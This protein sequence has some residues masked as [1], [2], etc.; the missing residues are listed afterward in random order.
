MPSDRM[1][2]PSPILAL[3]ELDVKH[4]DAPKRSRKHRPKCRYQ[5]ARQTGLG[6]RARDL[7]A[8]ADAGASRK[9]MSYNRSI[10]DFTAGALETTHPLGTARDL[11]GRLNRPGRDPANE[12][13]PLHGHK[14][15]MPASRPPDRA[16]W[17]SRPDR[18]CAG[19]TDPT[20]L[21]TVMATAVAAV[22]PC[23]S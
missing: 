23:A 6:P 9:A 18:R 3:A 4:A 11:Q 21:D 16:R 8:V 2:S 15:P 17:R 7:A 20:R 13:R 14:A 19:S 5:R 10:G 1:Q 22:G 12:D